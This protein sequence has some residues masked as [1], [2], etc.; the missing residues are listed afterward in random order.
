MK[1]QL[2]KI[3]PITGSILPHYKVCSVSFAFVSHPST[4]RVQLTEL[5]TCREYATRDIFRAINGDNPLFDF[6]KLRLLIVNDPPDVEIFKRRLFGGKAALNVLENMNNWDRSTI[7]SVNH[8]YYKNAW[9]L[10]GPAEWLH[11]P[12][13]FSLATWILR[14]SASYGELDT[15]DF[16]SLEKSLY[17]I[18]CSG[19]GHT[20]DETTYINKF[21]D[22]LFI[23]F[24]YYK[25]IFGNISFEDA[26]PDIPDT[27]YLWVHGGLLTFVDIGAVK[28]SKH[29]IEAQREF[30]N[31]CI[32]HL[33][34]TTYF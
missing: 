14:L 25:N 1:K 18:M 34:R 6:S 13:L 7:T 23:I 16:D 8:P 26:W 10:T 12:Q 5:V 20:M 29:I 22:K 19:N 17:K 28:Y 4:G 31:L 21:W 32:E 24:K 30:Q 2:I 11:H 9:L 15:N 27:D 33:P 3:K